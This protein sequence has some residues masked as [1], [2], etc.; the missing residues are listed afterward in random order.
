M[1]PN[2]ETT[3]DSRS[4]SA[5][6]P[7]PTIFRRMI[8]L[9][10]ATLAATMAAGCATPPQSA[11]EL[12]QARSALGAK[13]Y[14]VAESAADNYLARQPEGPRAAEANYLKGRALEDKV[15]S[16]AHEARTNLQ[17][18][19]TAYI[20]AL[21]V[22]TTDKSLE[23]LI[24]AA[25]ADVAYWQEDYVTTAEQGLAAYPLLG[26]AGDKAWTLYRAGLAQKRL[27]K[28]ADGDKTLTLVITQ[29]P[30]SEPAVR[31]QERLGMKDF[32]VQI[33][34][35]TQPTGIDKLAADL[36]KQGYAVSKKTA[37]GKTV[38]FVGPY[39]TYPQAV[40]A[41][42]RLAAKYPDAKVWP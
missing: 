1:R 4:A 14:A 33:A 9:T 36:Q 22:G 6:T 34:T 35:L 32:L 41:R 37:G 31:A 5:T 42:S 15:A 30:G 38:L 29:H 12:D 13:N 21:K 17:N 10:I 7:R 19:R 28:S 8:A 25:L 3:R 11:A 18:A 23:G 26:D 2:L 27:G 39:K 20:S 24:R 16:N 40:A